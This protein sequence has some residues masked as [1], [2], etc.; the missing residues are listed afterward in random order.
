M[1]ISKKVPANMKAIKL[2]L[3]KQVGNSLIHPS[4]K[5]IIPSLETEHLQS[6]DVH[7]R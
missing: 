2:S 3:L 7:L 6:G 4:V 1:I 5:S